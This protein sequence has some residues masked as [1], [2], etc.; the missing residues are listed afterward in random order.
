[1]VEQRQAAS[2][3]I[4]QWGPPRSIVAPEEVSEPAPQ[5]AQEQTVEIARETVGV[6]LPVRL[7]FIILS[8]SQ[9]AAALEHIIGAGTCEIVPA[10]IESRSFIAEV[11]IRLFLQE[12]RGSLELSATGKGPRVQ[13]VLEFEDPVIDDQ[14]CALKHT[15]DRSV[16]YFRFA[17]IDETRK[18]RRCLSKFQRSI[19]IHQSTTHETN[20]EEIGAHVTTLEPANTPLEPANTPISQVV[21]SATTDLAATAPDEEEDLIDIRYFDLVHRYKIPTIENTVEIVVDV[22]RGISRHNISGELRQP[23]LRGVEEAVF[24]HWEGSGFLRDRDE[25]FKDKFLNVVGSIVDFQV[26]VYQLYPPTDARNAVKEAKK[27][28]LDYFQYNTEQMEAQRGNATLPRN[29]EQV[30]S[31]DGPATSTLREELRVA[32]STPPAQTGERHEPPRTETSVVDS[33]RERAQEGENSNEAEQNARIRQ[34]LL[35]F[36]VAGRAHLQQHQQ[37]SSDTAVGNTEYANGDAV[38]S[39]DVNGTSPATPAPVPALPALPAPQAG[40]TP[41]TTTATPA[42]HTPMPSVARPKKKG[43]ADSLWAQAPSNTGFRVNGQGS[44]SRSNTSQPRG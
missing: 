16:L 21:T 13:D 38:N 7:E 22:F 6:S 3:T 33:V 8:V 28:L 27:E 20:L 23:V 1:M 29:L 9:D 10:K 5:S 4:A 18:F 25:A 37:S 41:I 39:G 26:L 44:A 36:G 31:L 19:R 35:V 40:V 43:L 34:R 15:S 11:K 24:S 14:F 12:N 42:T 32:G 30:R 2:P 17:D